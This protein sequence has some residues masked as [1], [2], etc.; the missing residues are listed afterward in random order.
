MPDVSQQ[1]D[2]STPDQKLEYIASNWARVQPTLTAV[3]RSVVHDPHEADDLIQ[4][5]AMVVIRKRETF[6]PGTSFNA[7]VSQIARYELM[8]WR[9]D[10]SRNIIDFNSEVIERLVETASHDSEYWSAYAV[11]LE[12]CL[13]KL[14]GR[15][16]EILSLR[17]RDNLSPQQI[18]GILSVTPNAISQVLARTKIK[19]KECVEQRIGSTKPKI[20]K[21]GNP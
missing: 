11:H 10:K 21:G 5:V 15:P 4:K 13:R 16:L 20:A 1:F 3:L 2:Q 17:Y 9:R 6:T 7:W 18:A 19:I 14:R 8:T 12:P